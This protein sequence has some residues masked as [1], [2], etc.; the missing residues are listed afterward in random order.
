MM[1]QS[2]QDSVNRSPWRFGFILI[3]LL[4]TCFALSPAVQADPPFTIVWG[5]LHNPRGLAF[6]ANGRLYVAEAGLGAGT[7]DDGIGFTGSI[8]EI[9][10]PGSVHPSFRIIKGGIVSH[11]IIPVISI[12]IRTRTA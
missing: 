11:G 3:P 1:A 5:G 12:P 8:D 6:G 2:I 7:T 10:N 4:L 9:S